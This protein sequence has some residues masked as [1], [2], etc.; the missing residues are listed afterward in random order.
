MLGVKT[1]I[2]HVSDLARARD[3]YARA[4]GVQPYF[5]E[6]FYVGFNIAGFELGLDPDT[7]NSSRGN[8]VVAY[9][10]VDDIAAEHDRLLALGAT[11]KAE[12]KDVGEGIKV[13]EVNDP[14]GN[15]IGLIQHPSP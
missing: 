10:G 6:P 8:S 5:D 14:F 11:R 3:W 12:I 15:A 7:S 4:F 1:V 2:Y 9:W 13:A